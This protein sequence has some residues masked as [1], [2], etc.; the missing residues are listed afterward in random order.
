M[1]IHNLK[2]STLKRPVQ[3]VSVMAQLCMKLLYGPFKYQAFRIELAEPSHNLQNYQWYCV[4][5]AKLSYGLL[6]YQSFR[7][8]VTEPL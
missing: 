4:K 2:D 5:G 6:N 1:I 8:K 3:V 7:A